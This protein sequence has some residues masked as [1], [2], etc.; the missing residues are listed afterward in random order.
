MTR[1][2]ERVGV[3][4]GWA[5]AELFALTGLAITQPVL[6]VVGRSPD[7]FLFRRAGRADIL[8]L[9]LGLMVL[10]ALSIW[11]LEVVAGLVSPTVRR[12]LHLVAVT[13][14]CTLLA[15]EV[16]KATTGLR[17]PSLAVIASVAGL[18]AGVLYAAMSW[19]RLWLR[20]LT[21]A[22]VVFALLFLLASPTSALVLPARASSVPAPS[23]AAAP[24]SHPPVVMVL[25]DEFPLSSLLDAKGRIDK[26]VYPNFA[27][28]AG[29]STWYRNATGVSGFTPWA[30]PAMLTGNYPAAARA[31]SYAEYPDNLFTLLGHDY[32]VRAYETISQLCPPRQCRSFVGDPSRSGLRA[33]AGDSARVLKELVQP[34]NAAFD[35]ALFVDLAPRREKASR[36]RFKQAGRNQP[37]RFNDFLAGLE[38]ADRPT[39]HFLH[40]LLPHAPWRFLPS[41]NEY[42]Y[43]KSFAGVLESERLP[44]PLVE[45]AHQQHLLQ[46]A[47]TDRL[48]GQVI[49]KLKAEDMWDR[50]LVV[51]GADHGEG[52]VPGEPSRTLRER[53][54]PD[55]MWVPQFI[56]TPGQDG[57]VVD[58]RN[59]EQV[60]LLPT[61][62][63]LA[64]VAVP[65]KTDGVSQTG[66][67]ARTRTAKWWFDVPGRRKVRDGPAN[68]KVVL[69]GETDTLAR[70]AE[71]VRGLYRY[72]ASADL[73]YRAPASVGPI[74]GDPV[75]AVLDDGRP[76]GTVDPGSGTVPALVS[77]RLN[78]PPP[79][80]A[81]VLAAVNGRIGGGSSLVPGRPGEPADR[82]AVI[83]PD[84]LWRAGDGRRQ[85]QLYLLDRSGGQPRLRPVSVTAR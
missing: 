49:A 60:D 56:K 73:V 58:D 78:S 65:W 36:F 18:L 19:P 43:N 75:S 83:T 80:G 41:G 17:G 72:G 6:D 54:A 59:W 32:E 70:A 13:G 52:W 79:P 71:G 25:F 12:H 24:G 66:K 28:L 82:F 31:P 61:V 21:P 3:E 57:G 68:W 64:G 29:R 5:L 34:Y 53:N 46:V 23:P 33:I 45:L 11:V 16:V 38:D 35:P 8:L 44:A 62:A 67:P 15:V 26:R 30:M 55:L 27:E 76:L 1:D 10:P 47:Y 40:L 7:M 74:G 14:L 81:T 22:P 39:L 50:S 4:G 77:G 48:V 2:V 9:V 51:I 20:F 69:A 37:A 84:F 42:N 63:D 85:L